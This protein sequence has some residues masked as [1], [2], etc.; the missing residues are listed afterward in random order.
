[1][2][3]LGACC[4]LPS[5]LLIL[6]SG[7][8]I[9]DVELVVSYDLPISAEVYLHRVGRTA[10]AGR[11]GTAVTLVT[12]HDIAHLQTIEAFIGLKLAE[13]ANEEEAVLQNLHDATVAQK[14]AEQTLIEIGF[15]ERR[16][17]NRIKR[18]DAEEE[19]K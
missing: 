4:L 5:H 8:D 17:N 6:A 1:M 13:H 10:R 16:R 3:Q 7:L 12:Q 2:L 18:R 15:G 14:I 11:G 19:E 9:P